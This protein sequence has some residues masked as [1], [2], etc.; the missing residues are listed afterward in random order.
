[1]RYCVCLLLC[2]AQMVVIYKQDGE[3]CFLNREDEVEVSVFLSFYPSLPPQGFYVLLLS[4][5]RIQSHLSCCCLPSALLLLLSQTLPHESKISSSTTCPSLSLS[6]YLYTYSYGHLYTLPVSTC[7]YVAT[8]I[9][10]YVHPYIFSPHMYIHIYAQSYLNIQLV[11]P[12]PLGVHLYRYRYRER[13]RDPEEDVCD[14]GAEADA[15][16]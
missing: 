5:E 14:I 16:K 9:C 6:L 4:T 10:I 12:C 7:L 3:V 2:L 15:V 8:Y 13:E 11:E 1:M